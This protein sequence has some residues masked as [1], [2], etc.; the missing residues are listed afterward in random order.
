MVNQAPPA[1]AEGRSGQS[2]N[3]LMSYLLLL[4]GL[5]LAA[6]AAFFL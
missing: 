3:Q 5:G 2:M 1:I 6:L 4:A